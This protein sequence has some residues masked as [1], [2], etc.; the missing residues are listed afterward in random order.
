VHIPG[1]VL[2]FALLVVG[3]RILWRAPP[4]F[5]RTFLLVQAALYIVFFWLLWSVAGGASRYVFPATLPLYAVLAREMVARPA[6]LKRW[7]FTGAAC[8]V[9]TLSLDPF[10]RRLPPGFDETQ[11]WL[12]QHLKPGEAYAVDSRSQLEPMW[13]LPAANPMVIVS[14]TWARQPLQPPELLPYLREK[15]VRYVV[16]D[17]S[18]HKDKDPR[19]L[20]FDHLPAQIPT[21]LRVAFATPGWQIL[22]VLPA[23]AAPEEARAQ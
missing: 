11:T 5:A 6:W 19:Y 7:A 1:V 17:Y 4:G 14:S 21:G 3:L 18:A 15:G 10:P 9:L 13:F 22:E 2:G 16:I 12:E 23:G 20:F 8:V